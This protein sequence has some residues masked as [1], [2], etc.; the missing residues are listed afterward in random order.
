MKQIVFL[1]RGIINMPTTSS[2]P[3]CGEN[4]DNE[5]YKFW[6]SREYPMFI[7]CFTCPYCNKSI[8]I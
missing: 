2:C 3:Y 8:Y 4:I 1:K 7:S 5:I 6:A